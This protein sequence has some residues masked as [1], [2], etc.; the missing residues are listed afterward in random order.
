M[1]INT[2]SFKDLFF[3]HFRK[4]ILLSKPAVLEI[5]WCQNASWSLLSQVYCWRLATVFQETSS[6]SASQTAGTDLIYSIFSTICLTFYL[7][8]N[9]EC[10]FHASINKKKSKRE[11]S[12]KNTKEQK[13]EG[14]CNAFEWDEDHLDVYKP[15]KVL[16]LCMCKLS[17]QFSWVRS[18]RIDRYLWER[19]CVCACVSYTPP[20]KACVSGHRFV[21]L[22][23]SGHNYPSCHVTNQVCV[24]WFHD[25]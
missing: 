20:H 9:L 24:T 2:F 18:K 10:T 7:S 21:L 6:W 11:F 8:A 15:V 5:L 23:K 13:G 19:V 1:S 3:F 4:N 25:K 17:L 12:H 22:V 16:L 14:L